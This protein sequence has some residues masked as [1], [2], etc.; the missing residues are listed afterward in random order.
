MV[1]APPDIG[2]DDRADPPP[3]PEVGQ[4]G[5]VTDQ[6]GLSDTASSE[7]DD[8]VADPDWAPGNG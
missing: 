5:P 7:I 1:D 4:E 6:N 2:Q 3:D 8:V